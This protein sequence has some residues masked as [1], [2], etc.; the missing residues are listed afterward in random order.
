LQPYYRLI[1]VKYG[2]YSQTP[3]SEGEY[4]TVRVQNIIMFI[5]QSIM[6][7]ALVMFLTTGISSESIS[8]HSESIR[9]RTAWLVDSL[10]Y[11][12]SK[13]APGVTVRKQLFHDRVHLY[14]SVFLRVNSDCLSVE[15]SKTDFSYVKILL[16]LKWEQ[17]TY[18]RSLSLHSAF[19]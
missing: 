12:L 3:K 2:I 10:N 5:Q 7:L 1:S 11:R 14:F 16:S 18:I 4:K 13:A 19:L 9:D 15:S 17:N 8:E 6:N